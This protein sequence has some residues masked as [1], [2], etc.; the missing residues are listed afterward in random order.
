M[1]ILAGISTDN[2]AA[3]IKELLP[4]FP[5]DSRITATVVNPD[6]SFLG[7]VLPQIR[8][9]TRWRRSLKEIGQIEENRAQ[10]FLNRFAISIAEIFPTIDK[11]VERG[12]PAKRLIS[13]ARKERID[14][15][16]VVRQQSDTNTTL[17]HVASRLVR[18]APCSVLLLDPRTPVPQVCMLST[19]GSAQAQIAGARLN[20]LLANGMFKVVVCSVVPSFRSVFMRT[21]TVGFDDDS[22][23]RKE[24]ETYQREAS[25]KIVNREA[26]RFQRPDIQVSKIVK[27][28]DEVPTILQG[29]KDCKIDLL[30][31]GTKGLSAQSRFLLGS[32]TSR[33]LGKT[34]CSV[35]VGR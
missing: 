29:I 32:V 35:L 23:L 15:M 28:G 20:S 24:V 31:V 22:R 17:G 8:S 2:D 11:R 10:G 13:V 9:A 7:R 34:R 1:R 5:R 12:N 19:D 25:E 26:V 27:T 3:A 4:V 21:G 16:V 18:Y 30:A 33:L 6:H 14:L